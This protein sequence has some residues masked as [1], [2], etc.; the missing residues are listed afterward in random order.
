[1]PVQGSRLAL[2]LKSIMDWLK[3]QR[4]KD[5]TDVLLISDGEFEAE[6]LEK[7][8]LLLQ[9]AN[10]HL[11]TLG[12]GTEAGKPIELKD[13]TWRRDAA[14]NVVISQLHEDDLRR[15]A[16]AGKGL[17]ERATYQNQDIQ[18]ILAAI[19]HKHDKDAKDKT[20]QRLWHERF[21]LL[22]ILMMLVILPWFQRQVT[23]LSR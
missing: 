6:D 11:H 13:G 18:A 9:D 3:G 20:Q 15:L 1:M 21:Y 10:F 8:L 17:Y 12:I 5:A 16:K 2:A 4:Y 7:S 19:Q 23:H 22:V 14:G